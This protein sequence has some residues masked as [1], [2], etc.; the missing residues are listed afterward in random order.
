MKATLSRLSLVAAQ[1]ASRWIAL[2]A[3]GP[4]VGS[5][6]WLL[7]HPSE[8]ASFVVSSTGRLP[9]GKALAQHL[10]LRPWGQRGLYVSV[11]LTAFFVVR[12]AHRKPTSLH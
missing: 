1:N 2:L 3:A 4:M 9:E 8:V 12:A 11:A 10:A 5:A 6:A 7:F